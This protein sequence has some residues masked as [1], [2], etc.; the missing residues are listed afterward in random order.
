V[1]EALCLLTAIC[2][3]FVFIYTIILLVYAVVSWIPDLRGRWTV[4]LA[5]LVEPVLTPLRRVLPTGGGL[6]WSF[7]VLILLLQFVVQPGLASVAG[8]VCFRFF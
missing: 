1:N 6:D 5:M 8:N 7:L 2:S 3:K 4:Y